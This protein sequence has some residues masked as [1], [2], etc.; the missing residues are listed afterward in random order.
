MT[1][2]SDFYRFG[3]KGRRGPEHH[4]SKKTHC[5]EGHEYTKEN[6]RIDRGSRAC[7]TCD[8]EKNYKKPVSYRR[9]PYKKRSR[10]V[11]EQQAHTC[12]G[13]LYGDDCCK[14]CN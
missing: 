11:D 8:R 12:D 1:S 14:A 9:G 4:N 13:G 10:S 6:T 2:H 5:P 7:R 3:K